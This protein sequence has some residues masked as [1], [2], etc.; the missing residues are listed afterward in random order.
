MSDNDILGRSRTH[1]VDDNDI[2]TLSGAYAVDAVDAAERARFEAHLTDCS[3]CRDE[4]ASLRAAA[5]ELASVTLASPPPSLRAAVLRDISSV[6]P[7]PPRVTEQAPAPATPTAA[8]SAPP[9]PP[10]AVPSAPVPPGPVGTAP[11]ASAPVASASLESKRAERARRAPLR[12]WLVGIAAAAVLATGGVVWHPWSA[13]RSTVQLTATQ[14]V[15]Q[16]KDAQRI[17]AKVGDATA[18]IVRSTSLRKAVIVTA[19]MPAAPEGK[20]YELWLQQGSAMVKAGLMPDGPANTVL[21]EGDAA[22]ASG[23]G[24]TV[25]PAGGSDTPTLPPVAVVAF[26]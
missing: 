16:A 17:E 12:Q 18:T 21:L 9:A 11:V 5:G 4:V 15:L 13:D 2:H 7:L 3:E 6:R 26:A 8:P 14:Q 25:E 22:T 24:I 1:D 23:V 19:N 10:T 20:V